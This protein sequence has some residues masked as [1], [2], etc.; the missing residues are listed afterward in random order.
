M[1]KLI[2]I[3]GLDASGKGT[4]AEILTNRLSCEGREVKEISLPNY[5]DPSA[6]LVKM[7]LSGEFGTDPESVNAYAASTFYAIDRYASF[8]KSWGKV[9]DEGDFIIA[10]RY[11]T[12]NCCH[13]M[14]KLPDEEWDDYIAWL[15][16]FEYG[17]MGIPK[18]DKV[19]FLDMPVEISQKLLL[20]RYGGDESKKDMHESNVE[21]LYKCRKAALYSAKKLG[22]VIIRCADGDEPR[23]I[24]DISEEI[25]SEIRE[26][27]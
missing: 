27:L 8:K 16:D 11:T 22:W 4:Q 7:Y 6:T 10:N 17:K 14:T 23:S 5:D 25:Y 9:Y 26:L 2:V 21:Y 24:E 20:K 3:E 12:S 15:R 19:I 13:Q 1:A 18:P